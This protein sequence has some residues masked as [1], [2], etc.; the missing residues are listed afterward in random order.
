V[1]VFKPGRPQPHTA[2]KL[3]GSC[4]SGALCDNDI[5]VI[6]KF[7]QNDYEETYQLKPRTLL[8]RAYFSVER[9]RAKNQS[10]ARVE[11]HAKKGRDARA[12]S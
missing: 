2:T 9:A 7:T 12:A 4:N 8:R 3:F 6:R 10:A 11:N 5:A 1:F